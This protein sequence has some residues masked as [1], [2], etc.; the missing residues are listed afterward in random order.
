MCYVFLG[1]FPNFCYKRSIFGIFILQNIEIDLYTETLKLALFLAAKWGVDLIYTVSTYTRQNTVLKCFESDRV[2]WTWLF[3]LSR[4]PNHDLKRTNFCHDRSW[5]SESIG[6][7]SSTWYFRDK[8]LLSFSR[9]DTNRHWLIAAVRTC[10]LDMT[11]N[12]YRLSGC[13]FHSCQHNF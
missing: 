9:S 11:D 2:Y 8:I 1:F 13:Y 6:G 12:Y 3:F 10:I 7:Q 4:L 5:Q